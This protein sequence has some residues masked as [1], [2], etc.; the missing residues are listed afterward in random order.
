[1]R[2]AVVMGRK[3]WDGIPPKFRPLRTRHNAVVSRAGID[4][5]GAPLTSVHG[6]VADALA[7]LPAETHR[8]FLIGGA[9]LYT[10]CL[11]EAVDRVLLTRVLAHIPCDVF[12]DDFAADARWRRAPHADLC[13]WLGWD[14][15]SGEVEENGFKYRFEMWVKSEGP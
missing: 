1:M 13:A 11:P 9:Q 5:G 15:P 7:G 12:L 10:Q 8:A 3:T 6:S 14:V 4:V 2:N